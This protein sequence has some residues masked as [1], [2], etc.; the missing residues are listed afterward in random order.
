VLE[1]YDELD[2]VTLAEVELEIFDDE[3]ELDVLLD[4]EL[5]SELEVVDEVELEVLDD[6]ELV[7]VL[8]LDVVVVVDD[9][10]V[11]V[12]VVVEV[13]EAELEVEVVDGHRVTEAAVVLGANG[14]R[15]D[16]MKV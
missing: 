3:V 6:E 11:V 12:V 15:T 14:L 13:F 10:D 2:E 7:D 4:E 9:F 16:L 1:E 8:I 5:V